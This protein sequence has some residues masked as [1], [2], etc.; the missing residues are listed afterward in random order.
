MALEKKHSLQKNFYY[1]K[2]KSRVLS[3]Y[4]LECAKQKKT[5][6]KNIQKG[7]YP[8]IFIQSLLINSSI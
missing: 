8:E 6:R 2:L 5:Q 1:K 7:L 3:Q 4:E